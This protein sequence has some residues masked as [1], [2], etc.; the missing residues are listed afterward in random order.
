M[1][2]ISY[3][4]ETCGVSSFRKVSRSDVIA[5]VINML[6]RIFSQTLPSLGTHGPLPPNTVLD[7]DTLR[8]SLHLLFHVPYVCIFIMTNGPR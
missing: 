4:E 6:I 5:H 3:D 7:V 8:H 2:G 1:N